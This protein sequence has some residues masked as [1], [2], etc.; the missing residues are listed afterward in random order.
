MSFVHLFTIWVH[1]CIR[2]ICRSSAVAAAVDPDCEFV[3]DLLTPDGLV[4][5][6]IGLIL[7]I[8]CLLGRNQ[9]DLSALNLTPIAE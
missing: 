3:T 7:S 9:I 5:P 6:L 4:G 8:V 1:I 2:R